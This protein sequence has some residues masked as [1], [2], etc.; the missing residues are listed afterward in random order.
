MEGKRE[1]SPISYYLFRGLVNLPMHELF[2]ELSPVAARM[3]N[4][5]YRYFRASALLRSRRVAVLPRR[6]VNGP[7]VLISIAIAN[8]LHASRH[9]STCRKSTN[10]VR[11]SIPRYSRRSNFVLAYARAA[12][13]DF[14]YN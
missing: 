10:D 4:A 5:A 3:P 1:D 14:H 2:R 12:H 8:D 13:A 9:N 11:E 6:V 7:G